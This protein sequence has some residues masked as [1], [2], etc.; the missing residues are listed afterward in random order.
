MQGQYPDLLDIDDADTQAAW[1]HDTVGL[2]LPALTQK[3]CG[4]NAPAYARATRL[5]EKAMPSRENF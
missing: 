1:R 5:E 3:I 4:A 2:N